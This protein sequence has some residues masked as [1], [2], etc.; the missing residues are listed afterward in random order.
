MARGPYLVG[1]VG[2]GVG[3]SLTP[4]LHMAEASAQGLDYLYRTIDLNE[5]GIAPTRIGEVLEWAR[6]LGYNALN[7]THPCKRLVIEHLDEIDDVAAEL[8]AVNTVVFDGARAVGYNTDTTGFALGFREGLPGAATDNVVLIGAGGAGAAVGD[9]LLRLGTDHLTIVDVDAERATA[10]ARELSTRRPEARVDASSPDK[11]AVLLP[12]S[13]GVVHCTPTGMA[14]HPGM[15]FSAELL[16]PGLWVAD[17]VY[18]PLDTA[19][20]RAALATGCRVCD[21]GHMAVHQAA[22]AFALITGIT[23]DAERMS[24]HFRRLVG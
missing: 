9:A 10:L 1:L 13:D 18:R 22:E 24:R 12:A 3:P 8:G 19:L 17:I 16:A 23:P 4:S 6:A 21:G 15:P 20:L 11:L 2:T 14:D 7:I 5:L